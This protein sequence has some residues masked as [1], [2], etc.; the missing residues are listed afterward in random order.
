M[1]SEEVQ[2]FVNKPEKRAFEVCLQSVKC[3]YDVT[4]R[5]SHS[6]KR[7]SKP[8]YYYLSARRVSY[9]HNFFRG[10]SCMYTEPQPQKNPE[11]PTLQS[12]NVIK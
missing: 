10:Y 1:R 2:T 12:Q 7:L 9:R 8:P 6:G 5:R 11:G 3:E 4:L